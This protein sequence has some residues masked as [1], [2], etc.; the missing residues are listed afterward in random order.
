MI[1]LSVGSNRVGGYEFV[2][3]RF[4]IKGK[5]NQENTDPF[6]KNTALRSF[7]I[8]LEFISWR[9]VNIIYNENIIFHVL[10]MNMFSMT[11]LS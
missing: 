2:I 3:N 5:R 10:Y 11:I 7:M 1:S 9:L 8:H 6:N 4:N